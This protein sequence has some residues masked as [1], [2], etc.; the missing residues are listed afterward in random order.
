MKSINYE[1]IKYL[2]T[3]IEEVKNIDTTDVSQLQTIAIELS[4]VTDFIN[5]QIVEI[6]S[7][8]C[9]YEEIV[10]E[11]AEDKIDF[12]NAIDELNKERQIEEINIT[13]IN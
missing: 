1:I 10:E 8:Y 4:N 13:D 12:I 5:D 11:N 9:N 7:Q 3:L 6:T 2:N